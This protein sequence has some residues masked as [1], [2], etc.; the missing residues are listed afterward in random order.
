LRSSSGLIK[1]REGEIEPGLYSKITFAGTTLYF[2]VTS[3]TKLSIL[4]MYQRLF[5]ISSGFRD[6]VRVLIT[7]V[8]AFWAGC[9]V[10]QL[11]SCIPFERA[12]MRES[13]ELA[14][15]QYYNTFWA[16]SGVLES[17]IDLMI[18]TLPLRI[19]YR[20]QISTRNKFT[21]LGVFLLVVLWVTHYPYTS[22]HNHELTKLTHT[23]V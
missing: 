16:A 12:W 17:L 14:Q 11:I 23:T 9:T 7:I 8:V 2:S 19:I 18:I 3:T 4:L 6:Q 21:L 5:S 10:T 13:E 20:L 1:S 22:S 15:C